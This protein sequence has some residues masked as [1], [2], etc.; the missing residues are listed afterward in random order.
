MQFAEMAEHV[1]RPDLDRARTAGMKPGRAARHNLQRLRRRAGR[2]QNA[3]R[4]GFG[5]E[6]I[7]FAVALGPIAP[8]AGR[9]R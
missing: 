8:E 5:I 7:D 3:D 9:L 1:L 4:I 2:D 6:R